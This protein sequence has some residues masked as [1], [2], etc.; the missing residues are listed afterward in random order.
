MNKRRPVPLILLVLVAFL[1]PI[2][3]G[4]VNLDTLPVFGMGDVLGSLWGGPEAAILAHALLA[5]L[6]CT[7]LAL[8]LFKRKIIQVPNTTI[9]AVLLMFFGLLVGTISYSS[10]RYLSIQAA[11]EWI[12]YGIAFYA[13]IAG[14]GRQR[15]PAEIVAGLTLGCTVV[16]LK[17]IAEYV[18]TMATDPTWRIFAGWVNPNATATM[19]LVGFFCAL[20]L[21]V[22]SQR[23]LA[24]AW[25][26]SAVLNG[27]A[28]L[29]TQSK[30][31]LL[32]LGFFSVFML[33]LVA[34]WSAREGLSRVKP[35]V[36][37]MLGVVAALLM[38]GLMLQVMSRSPSGGG[39]MAR[40]TDTS[41]TA[42]QS[43][44][45]RINLW[46]GAVAMI[47]ER[48]I[49]YGIG[50]YRYESGSP[51]ITPQTH[52]AH[53]TYLQLGAEA[54]P[55]APLFLL[56]VAGLW[57]YHVFRGARKTPVPQNLLRA[58]V[59][60]AVLAVGAHSLIDSDF[61]YYGVGLATFMLLGVGLL[62]SVDAV[63]P[64]NVPASVRRISGA[65]V[66][67]LAI[68]FVFLG[69]ADVLKGQ[70]RGA[71]MAQDRERA[72]SI[73]GPLMSYAGGDAEAWALMAQVA[74]T[75]EERKQALE[76]AAELG[77]STKNLRAL[78][79]F[80]AEQGQLPQAIG[81]LRKALLRDPNNLLSLWL[82]SQF[83]EDTGDVDGSKRTLQRLVA[84]EETPYFRIRALPELVPT[85]TYEGRIKLAD[86]EPDLGAKRDLLTK[87][88]AGFKRYRQMTVPMIKT[89]SAGG[90]SY[91]GE[92]LETMER[93]M[94]LATEK[95]RELAAIQ[96]RG[97]DASGA[98]AT[99][100]EAEAFA[101]V[102]ESSK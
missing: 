52:L 82:L 15:G 91:G 55:L 80:Q 65:G 31:G 13:V 100:A 8:L 72:E 87:A 99:D 19:L 92:N 2:A 54:S 50:T 7:A 89:M 20:G 101:G 42:E 96:R 12:T 70:M 47:R 77:P 60:A 4:Q 71:L 16:A 74:S 38:A 62:L 78:A 85:E 23:N 64:E 11:T 32:V 88:L 69:M 53:Q 30:G 37:R 79:R 18:S 45:F 48:P 28:I 22:S 76:T 97:G 98:T 43:F 51:G 24:A 49:G 41:A 68:L 34:L 39:A 33:C 63:A 29:L 73:K 61:S 66:L 1:A 93:K 57:F 81:N 3:G 6:P 46:R 58:G 9:S 83:Q 36:G 40:V 27:V 35:A 94:T 17:A 84:V 25:G 21:A 75:A 86:A 102:L 59:I 10:F 56:A 5:L 14:A 26:V 44:E 67:L 90:T 95:A